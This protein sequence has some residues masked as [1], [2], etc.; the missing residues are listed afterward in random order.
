MVVEWLA[1]GR[2]ILLPKTTEIQKVKNYGPIT[3]L[4][5]DFKILDVR[6]QLRSSKALIE[7]CTK[8]GKKAEFVLDRLPEGV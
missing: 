1:E 6:N 2:T 8:F 3:C 4:N 5:I 7:D